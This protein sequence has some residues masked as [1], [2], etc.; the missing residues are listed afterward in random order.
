[1]K[2]VLGGGCFWCLEAAYQMLRGVEGVQSGY[3]GGDTPHPSYEDVV[4]GNTGHAEVVEVD[5]DEAVVSLENIM[6]IF[7]TVHDP[8][9]L[10]RQGADVGTQYRSVIFYADETQK[11]VAETSLKEAQK[12]WD[13]PIVTSIEPLNMFYPAE[14]YHKDYFKNHPEQAYCQ[15]VINPKLAKLRKLHYDLLNQ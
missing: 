2:I 3:A 1:M 8:T 5:F 9:S 4:R 13:E 14:E 15:I 7:W 10:N 6:N 12:L 11:Q